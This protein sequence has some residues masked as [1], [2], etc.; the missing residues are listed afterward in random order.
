MTEETTIWGVANS[1]NISATDTTDRLTVTD[2]L[3]MKA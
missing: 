1:A 3:T 2:R